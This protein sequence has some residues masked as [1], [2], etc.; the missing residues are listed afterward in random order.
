M[1]RRAPASLHICFVLSTVLFG[2][3]PA[4]LCADEPETFLKVRP[5]QT[6]EEITMLLNAPYETNIFEKTGRPIWGPEEE[7]WD[8][9]PDST[10]LEVWKYR[11]EKGH[12][13]I[14]F[15]YPDDRAA[16]KAFAPAGVVY[17]AGP[18]HQPKKERK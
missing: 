1:T 4:S 2:T 17:E 12:L 6:K 7:F 18:A 5:G 11:H 14:Y 13:N 9:I 15:L 10:M 8:R 16:Y 3:I